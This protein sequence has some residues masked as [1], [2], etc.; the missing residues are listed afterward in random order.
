VAKQ[1]FDKDNPVGCEIRIASVPFQVIG[2]LA[3]KGPS[4][5]GQNQD[6]I[7]FV[8]ISTAKLRLM[9]GA[10]EVNREAVAYILV[11]A[12]SDEAMAVAQMQIEALLRQRHRIGS[13][14]ESDFQVS[15]PAAAMAAQRASTTTIAWLLAAISSVSLLVGGI[16]IMNIMLVSVTERTRE[17]GLRLAVGARR[18]DIRNQFSHRSGDAPHFRRLSRACSRSRR[19]RRRGQSCGVADLSRDRRRQ[20]GGVGSPPGSASSLAT[21]R[22]ER[23]RGSS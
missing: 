9:G 11:N 21:I 17:I 12:V 1:L 7:V 5:A 8:P 22:R 23:Q 20:V 2:V 15:N 3:E 4:G 18:R 14:G 19:G 16:S 6:D 13:D 10:S